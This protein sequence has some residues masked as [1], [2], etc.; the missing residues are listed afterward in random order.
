MKLRI[1]FTACL[2]LLSVTQAK[3][4]DSYFAASPAGA[5]N[6]L[7]GCTAARSITS[8][9]PS[10]FAPDVN[11]HL[12]GKIVGSAGA[13]GIT[14]MGSGTSGHPVTITFEPG[15]RLS[16]PS[17]GAAIYGR[18][19]SY[20]IVDGGID[21]VIEN[22][23]AGS[24]G[25]SCIGGSCSVS[26]PSC[27]SFA[28]QVCSFTNFDGGSNI[29]IKNLHLNN[30]YVHT[31]TAGDGGNSDAVYFSAS[32]QSN[33][34]VHDNVCTNAHA[35]VLVSYLAL[36]GAQVYNN[37]TTNHVWGV[38]FLDDNSGATATGVQVY[39]NDISGFV[40]WA[41]PSGADNGFHF[42]GVFFAATNGSTKFT[43]S[44][45]YN[46][47]LHGAFTNPATGHIYLSGS[48]GGMTGIAIYN[49]LIVVPHNAIGHG[50]ADEEGLI[51]LGFNSKLTTVVG[52]TLISTTNGIDIRD[53]GTTVAAIKN[54][55]FSG[56]AT[57]PMYT[58]ILNKTQT[59][60]SGN[61]VNNNQYFNLDSRH[62]WQ[63]GDGT[64][65]VTALQAWRTQC[66]CD[67]ASMV[68]DPVL[69]ANYR[70]TS[71]SVAIGLGANLSGMGISPLNFDKAGGA[72]PAT[73][74][75]TV[76][77]YNSADSS[78]TRLSPPTGLTIVIH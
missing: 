35:C 8:L 62:M 37:T 2:I 5:G 51:V 29:E 45:I 33:L 17:W 13:T 48:A 60:L 7:A 28:A 42:D 53:G 40:N 59:D 9:S 34:S 44:S 67:A 77:A 19:R 61:K 68:A 30:A 72:R 6:G 15:A 64:I 75:W 66:G 31:G 52:N 32:T 76:G 12:C 78:P 24:S 16:S 27:D 46:N 38:A 49:N 41:G 36:S 73:T 11:I 22:T 57:G 58:S 70:P 55:I 18:G 71:T 50:G 56:D 21:G 4:A 3:A 63:V 25:A 23:L 69:D 54:N 1:L 39:G 65:N 43:N 26:N 14:V 47:Y 74:A 10:D 20:V